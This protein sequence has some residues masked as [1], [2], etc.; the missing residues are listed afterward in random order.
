MLAYGRLG[1]QWPGQPPA[2]ALGVPG[3]EQ[4]TLPASVQTCCWTAATEEALLAQCRLSA[5]SEA[6]GLLRQLFVP[7]WH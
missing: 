1:G 6:L 3:T 7:T 4:D 5:S 2:S